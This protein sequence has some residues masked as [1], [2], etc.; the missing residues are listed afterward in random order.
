M[1]R[2]YFILLLSAIAL[3]FSASCSKD[4]DGEDLKNATHKAVIYTPAVGLQRFT[5]SKV[6]LSEAPFEK[7][8]N[9]T[10]LK[11]LNLPANRTVNDSV[12]FNVS[13][14]VGK[15]IYVVAL[16]KKLLSDGYYSITSTTSQPLK[17]IKFTVVEDKPVYQVA[18]VTAEPDP[19]SFTADKAVLTLKV[20]KGNTLVSNREVYWYGTTQLWND[21]HKALI[22]KEY[23]DNGRISATLMN[24]TDVEGLSKISIPVNEAGTVKNGDKVVNNNEHVF[25]VMEAGKVKE[26]IVNVDNLTLAKTLDI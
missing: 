12:V 17:N 7:Y 23:K 13:D 9:F 21:Q 15:T 3:F 20:K 1:K 24:K 25:F 19:K 10:P 4:N 11:S 2:N 5:D 26:I 14:Y 6:F 16:R 8:E 22:E 18:F